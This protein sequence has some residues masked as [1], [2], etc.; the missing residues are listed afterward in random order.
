MIPII[1]SC[2]SGSPLR[3][4][5]TLLLAGLLLLPAA[6]CG[7]KES[8]QGDTLRVGVALYTQDDTF[9]STIVQNLEQMALGEE[10]QTLKINLSTADGRSNQTTQLE[11]VDGF[12]SR[13]CDVLCV[14]IVDRTA[15][16]VIVDKAQEAGIP[17]IFF[18]R[19]PVAEDIQRWEQVYYVGVQAEE[20]GTIQGDLVRDAWLSDQEN[21][22]RNG[23]GVLQYVMLEGEPG[24][25]D[26]LLR[27]EYSIKALTDAGIEVEKLASDTAN[28]NRG[29]AQAKME[30]WL[31]E[32]G[33][34][35][36]V[37]FSNNH[38]MALGA[39]DA[40]REAGLTQLPLVVGVDATAPALEAVAA[41]ELYG[42][43][44][45]DAVGIARNMMDLIL[46]LHQGEDPGQAVAL[47]DRHYVWL[48]SRPV[49][50][51]NLEEFSKDG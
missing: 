18:N 33:G 29:Q 34:Q 22:D 20:G 50:A 23:D 38:D 39:I 49:T 43:V 44:L 12:L 51:E 45:N 8:T 26:A 9:I 19:Q 21:L 2:C 7:G 32:F 6:G 41:G 10:T 24:H 14:N 11:Q 17:L 1:K 13:G 25:Q 15:A 30:Q 5:G 48:P 4:L 37:I 3:R 42:T 46:A 27:T 16:A 40:C 28:W 35:I 31:T 47:E 36:E